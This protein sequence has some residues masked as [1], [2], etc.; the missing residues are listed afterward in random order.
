MLDQTCQSYH[1]VLTE[2]GVANHT[3]LGWLHDSCE[4]VKSVPPSQWAVIDRRRRN[5]SAQNGN[6]QERL[7]ACWVEICLGRNTKRLRPQ[8]ELVAVKLKNVLTEVSTSDR[9]ASEFWW[10]TTDPGRSFLEQAR[11]YAE[12]VK[13]SKARNIRYQ[14]S[15]SRRRRLRVW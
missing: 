5:P 8:S 7:R 15:W 2:S 12:A 9:K 11:S 4:G 10:S 3:A 14:Y 6:L 1:C 13:Q